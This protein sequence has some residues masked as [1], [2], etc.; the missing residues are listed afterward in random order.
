[1]QLIYFT[2]FF[3]TTFN[4]LYNRFYVFLSATD[5]SVHLKLPPCLRQEGS[6][7]GLPQLVQRQPGRP[8]PGTRPSRPQTC[9]L[10]TSSTYACTHGARWH[11]ANELV[12]WLLLQKNVTFC[13][14]ASASSLELIRGLGRKR[15][16]RLVISQLDG[17]S[18]SRPLL[19]EVR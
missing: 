4:K 14:P 17:F 3:K 1:M 10:Y 19:Q 2:L 11:L 9:C 5:H 18:M 16:C 6:G 12:C 13:F 7:V 15:R 8:V